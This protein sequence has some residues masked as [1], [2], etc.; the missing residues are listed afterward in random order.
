MEALSIRAPPPTQ[1][2]T[3]RARKTRILDGARL[4]VATLIQERAARGKRPRLPLFPS[5]HPTPRRRP[6]GCAA[7]RST[8]PGLS[9]DLRVDRVNDPPLSLTGEGDG[10]SEPATTL[11][12]DLLPNTPPLA[13]DRYYHW[14]E[15]KLEEVFATEKLVPP[16]GGRPVR[17]SPRDEDPADACEGYVVRRNIDLYR[18][19]CDL[20]TVG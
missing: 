20:K 7:W 13:R 15:H 17:P 12:S 10:R 11:P 16:R 4:C 9:P 6:V 19:L 3:S 1:A 14:G 8:A 5:P 18:A 2:Q